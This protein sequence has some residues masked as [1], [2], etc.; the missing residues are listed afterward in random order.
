MLLKCLKQFRKLPLQFTELWTRVRMFENVC[1]RLIP[2]ALR[3]SRSPRCSQ[4][5]SDVLEYIQILSGTFRYAL[6][7]F[8]M[9]SNI[10]QMLP[11]I[12]RCS[13]ILIQMFSE[14]ELKQN[15][16]YL[17]LVGAPSPSQNIGPIDVLGEE[18]CSRL[19]CSVAM[20]LPNILLIAA[21]R[22]RASESSTYSDES[23]TGLLSA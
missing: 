3:C 6:G 8:Q 15:R 22:D 20:R 10:F 2:D 23:V 11:N 14:K 4:I 21:C 5:L 18:A 16:S 9:L 17:G 13:Q 1:R 19:V 7:Y 12:F